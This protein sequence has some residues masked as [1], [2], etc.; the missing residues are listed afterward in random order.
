MRIRP[1]FWSF[2]PTDSEK[3][4]VRSTGR[5]EI[6]KTMAEEE[7]AYLCRCLQQ[8]HL[9]CLWIRL[10]EVQSDK[11]VFDIFLCHSQFA[12][13]GVH[14]LAE[15][16]GVLPFLQQGSRNHAFPVRG[17]R[18]ETRSRQR[19]LWCTRLMRRSRYDITCNNNP[20]AIMENFCDRQSSSGKADD[21]HHSTAYSSH[22][23]LTSHGSSANPDQIIPPTPS[24]AHFQYFWLKACATWRNSL[25]DLVCGG[26]TQLT[27]VN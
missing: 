25:V 10:D 9:F 17:E 4:K 2:L 19:A 22:P 1:V 14:Q 21:F 5:M 11:R 24:S 20:T 13:H 6:K 16:V 23:N 27:E 7:S 15:L 26:L 8:H 12:S 18:Q 3:R